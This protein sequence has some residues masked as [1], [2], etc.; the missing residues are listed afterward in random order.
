MAIA[1]TAMRKQVEGQLR[2]A[3]KN[4]KKKQLRKKS[5]R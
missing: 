5:K 4:K 1:R 3:R 2:G